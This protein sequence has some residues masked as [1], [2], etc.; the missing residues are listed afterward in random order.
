MWGRI[1]TVSFMGTIL[2]AGC[3]IFSNAPRVRFKNIQHP[4]TSI[5]DQVI[6]PMVFITTA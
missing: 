3:W 2:D 4:E 1:K 5:Q 6:S